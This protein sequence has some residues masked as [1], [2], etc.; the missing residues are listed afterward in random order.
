MNKAN[1]LLIFLNIGAH[2]SQVYKNL[3]EIT[4]L[5]AVKIN[6]DDF[7]QKD[8]NTKAMS[9]LLLEFS[10][11]EI[12]SQIKKALED[13]D[14]NKVIDII[15]DNNHIIEVDKDSIINAKIDKDHNTLLHIAY[16]LNNLAAFIY[17]YEN[18][19]KITIANKNGK[20]VEDLTTKNKIFGDAITFIKKNTLNKETVVIPTINL[21]KQARP[22]CFALKSGMA[23]FAFLP[24]FFYVVYMLM[25]LSLKH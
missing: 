2:A 4:P 24:T 23:I 5:L 25:N 11:N 13:K 22:N 19:G 14:F 10:R 17:F 9:S 20:S 1:F 12:L 16:Y 18:G 6:E 3:D 21:N 7:Y 8:S 15:N